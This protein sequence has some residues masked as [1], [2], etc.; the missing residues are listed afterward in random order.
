MIQKNDSPVLPK[1]NWVFS[2]N[3][4]TLEVL[5]QAKSTLQQELFEDMKFEFTER[6][7][8]WARQR[9]K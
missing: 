4:K 3:T 9:G 5:W 1:F 6:D 2:Y 7:E 8:E